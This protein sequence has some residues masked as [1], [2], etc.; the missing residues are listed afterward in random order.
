MQQQILELLSQENLTVRQLTRLL[1]PSDY[2]YPN[3]DDDSES[4]KKALE[5]T[6]HHLKKLRQSKLVV[7]KP[8]GRGEEYLYRLIGNK[9]IR[10]LGYT[11]QDEAHKY[12]YDHEK[13]CADIF[14]AL[15]LTGLLESWEGTKTVAKKFRPDRTFRLRGFPLKFFLEMETGSQKPRELR[16]KIE[17]YISYRR[18]TGDEF[19]TIWIGQDDDHVNDVILKVFEEFN[20]SPHYLAGVF[21]GFTAAPLSAVLFSRFEETTLHRLSK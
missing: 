4:S 17:R 7:G 12:L 2:P 16:E 10:Q 19:H 6:R 21:P 13:L 1:Y 20:V 11:P 3:G 14:A 8:Y 15:T 9:T 5:R 18:E